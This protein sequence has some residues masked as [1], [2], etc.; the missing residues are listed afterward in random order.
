MIRQRADI[1]VRRPR[2]R[3]TRQDSPIRKPEPK[4]QQ[5]TKRKIR[6]W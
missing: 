6:N 5:Q 3:G 4:D 2:K 1:A